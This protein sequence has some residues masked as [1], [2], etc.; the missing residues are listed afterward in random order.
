MTYCVAMRLDAG[1]VFLSDSR[2]NAGVDHVGTFR[3]MTVYENPGERML[4]L[5]TA[6]NLSISQSIKNI[7][8]ERINA[9]GK[10]IW[11]ASTMFEAAQIVG[12]AIRTVRDRESDELEKSGIEFNVGIIFGGQIKG[13]RCRLFQIYSAG[14]F[15]EAQDANP[16]FQIGEAK[17]GKPIIDRVIDSKTALDTAAKCALLSMNST[18]H[19]NVSVGM[20][21]DLLVYGTDDLAITRFVSI[22]EKNKYYQGIVEDWGIKIKAMFSTIEEPEWSSAGDSNLTVEKDIG[23][24]LVTPAPNAIASNIQTKAV[25]TLAQGANT[26]Q[27]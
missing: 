19:S 24:S 25:Q 11:T 14:N 8:A 9:D 12:E 21:L 13:E 27:S 3:K 16:Y 18:L 4:V 5:M 2:T 26:A 6:G 20:P 1:L 17:Y 22:D 23:Q 15:I 7:I 10:S